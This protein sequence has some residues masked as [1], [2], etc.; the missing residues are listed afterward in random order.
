ME[1]LIIGN[2]D[3]SLEPL[4]FQETPLEIHR[5]RTAAEAAHYLNTHE[6]DLCLVADGLTDAM[7]LCN[8][9]DLPYAL[10][11]DAPTTAGLLEAMNQGCCGYF[12]PEKP[13]CK[14]LI[15]K[16]VTLAK[17]NRRQA[18]FRAAAEESF[19]ANVV[20]HK[21]PSFPEELLAEADRFGISV[22][23]P[24]QPLYIRCRSRA[25]YWT[26]TD[27][28]EPSD[29]S[30]EL[31]IKAQIK[32][33]YFRDFPNTQFIAVSPHR[34]IV[35]VFV[36]AMESPFQKIQACCEQFLADCPAYALDALCLM[37]DPADLCSLATQ[38]ERLI[39]I[40]ADQVYLDNQFLPSQQLRRPPEQ[41]PQPNVERYLTLLDGGLYQAAY[42][43]LKDFFYTPS[44][45]PMINQN[46]LSN[47]CYQF[48]DG[49]RELGIV[50]RSGVNIMQNIPGG[51]IQNASDSVQDFLSFFNM[52]TH[53]LSALDGT[54]N[55]HK[56]LIEE[57]KIYV[58]THLS[59]CLG[60]D[61][62]AA[63]FFLSADYL[64]RLFKR[65]SGQTLTDFILQ[66]RIA[67]AK[68]LLENE[69]L[70]ISD[71]SS[72]VGFI[73]PSHFSS[74]FKKVTG[75]SPYAYRK[76]LDSN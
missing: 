30:V 50:R 1:L 73:N 75:I 23:G 27:A 70:R 68:Q 25:P 76:Q 51:A 57:V 31:M 12:S 8:H 67:L 6:A 3:F 18:L 9:L 44:V 17:E 24:I 37:G 7:A 47:F 66:S 54:E 41:P 53:H 26:Q 62:I 71:I 65:E 45:M 2:A 69:G 64:D 46:F 40:G 60:R 13:E 5:A 56:N 43:E 48:T 11:G 59:T 38:T 21:A 34:F 58:Q 61:T 74:A 28:P 29:A 36:H 42:E 4:H 10:F 55:E 19:W 22:G 63:Q 72:K 35:L 14:G 49:L 52:I 20:N 39:Q 16:L 15:A 32:T 33:N